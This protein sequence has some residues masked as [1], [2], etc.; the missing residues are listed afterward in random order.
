MVIKKTNAKDDVTKGCEVG[1]K[2]LGSER[3]IK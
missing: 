1:L 3:K 2:E